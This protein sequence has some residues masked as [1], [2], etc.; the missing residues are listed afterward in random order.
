M[1]DFKAHDT[2]AGLNAYKILAVCIFC[3]RIIDQDK[4]L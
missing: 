4:I 2:R 1:V 3:A